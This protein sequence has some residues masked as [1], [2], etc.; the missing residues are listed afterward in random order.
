MLLDILGEPEQKI[1]PGPS[2][3]QLWL[4][5]TS[6]A[7]FPNPI[8]EMAESIW[9]NPNHLSI[10]GD[11]VSVISSEWQYIEHE[12]NGVELYNLNDD[13]NQ[14]NNLASENSTVLD[15]L[16]NYYLDLLTRLGMTWPYDNK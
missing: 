16:K 7:S 2:L 13:L 4:D 5:P 10:K 15:E 3:A 1:F 9:V 11:M 6:A 12:F 14:E 8:A